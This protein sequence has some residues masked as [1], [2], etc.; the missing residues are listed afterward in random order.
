MRGN[1]GEKREGEINPKRIKKEK[2]RKENKIKV[3]RGMLRMIIKNGSQEAT[4]L[5]HLIVIIRSLLHLDILTKNP[6]SLRTWEGN[7]S[8][9][10]NHPHAHANKTKQN[11]NKNKTKIASAFQ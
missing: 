3:Q 9:R 10:I 5:I 8:T 1:Q 7:N 11:K 6:E 2:K 4:K